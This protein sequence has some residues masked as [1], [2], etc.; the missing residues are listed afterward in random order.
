MS[1]SLYSISAIVRSLSRWFLD[2]TINTVA[3]IKNPY[4][5]S[6]LACLFQYLLKLSIYMYYFKVAFPDKA[7]CFLVFFSGLFVFICVQVKV[8]IIYSTYSYNVSGLRTRIRFQSVSEFGSM[9]AKMTHKSRKGLKNF[10]FW[11]VGCSLLRAEGFFCKMLDL[12]PDEMNA[13]PQPC[14]VW[15][16]PQRRFI[17]TFFFVLFSCRSSGSRRDENSPGGNCGHRQESSSRLTLK[18]F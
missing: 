17:F 7:L 13:D 18:L 11:S 9:W 6:N 5:F 16:T 2:K 4:I 1:S 3:V 10:M 12:D 14:N 15:C 8:N